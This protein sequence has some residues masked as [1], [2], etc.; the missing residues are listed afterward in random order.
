MIDEVRQFFIEHI[1]PIIVEYRQT[2]QEFKK[3]G[4]QIIQTIQRQSSYLED[5]SKGFQSIFASVK[6]TSEA[7]Q[8]MER[9]TKELREL[10][11]NSIS[12]LDGAIHTIEQLTSEVQYLTG[13]LSNVKEHSSQLKTAIAEIIKISEM[14]IVASRNAQI[15]AYHAGEIGRGFEVIARQVVDLVGQTETATKEIPKITGRIE[16]EVAK[17]GVQVDEMQKFL[18]KF[19]MVGE[20]LN[21]SFKHILSIVPNL[22]RDTT[23]ASRL[24]A[25]QEGAKKTLVGSNWELNSWLADTFDLSEKAASA[26]IFLKGLSNEIVDK[27]EQI[28]KWEDTSK[29]NLYY[30]LIRFFNVL[31]ITTESHLK[32]TKRVPRLEGVF[33][34]EGF[35]TALKSLPA[36]SQD[37]KQS[38]MRQSTDLKKSEGILEASL[39]TLTRETSEEAN[40]SRILGEAETLL[41]QLK[42]VPNQV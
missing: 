34:F 1:N 30:F 28:R 24:I 6:L 12:S 35:K 32:W 8:V 31:N 21:D 17:L 22:E 20:Y 2:N 13:A 16:D 5:L 40:I 33:D 41:S 19:E 23:E 42:E 3:L 25:E 26:S 36:M 39:N 10:S 18:E 9:E 4:D 37:I 7:T 15:K 38:I 29:H 27:A 11:N 14:T